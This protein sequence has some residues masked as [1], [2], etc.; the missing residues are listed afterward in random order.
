MRERSLAA[1]QQRSNV[2]LHAGIHKILSILQ[3][4]DSASQG[5]DDIEDQD[6]DRVARARGL[7]LGERYYDVTRGT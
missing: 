5:T 7:L 4:I 6:L 1:Q 3:A 2:S